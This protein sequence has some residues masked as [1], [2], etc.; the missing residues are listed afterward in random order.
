MIE[1]GFIDKYEIKGGVDYIIIPIGDTVEYCIK[2]LKIL[3]N[4]TPRT[5]FPFGVQKT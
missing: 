4:K 5:V 2:I 1:I 3:Q